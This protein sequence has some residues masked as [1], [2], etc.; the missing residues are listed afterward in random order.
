MQVLGPNIK[1]FAKNNVVGIFEQG[2]TGSLC[3]DFVQLRD[4]VISH[5]LWDPSQ[6]EQKLFQEFIQGYYGDAA[7]AITAYLDLLRDAF[8]GRGYHLSCYNKETAFLSLEQMNQ[9]TQLFNDAEKA[10]E[11]NPELLARVKRERIS[12][13]H[14]W[15]LRYSWLKLQAKVT[16]SPFLGPTDPMAACDDLLQRIRKYNNGKGQYAEGKPVDAYEPQLKNMVEAGMSDPATAKTPPECAGLD[17]AKWIVMQA[18]Q[19]SIHSGDIHVENDPAASNGK[20]VG[21]PGSIYDWFVRASVTGDVA[22]AFPKAQC[23]IS[24]RCDAISDDPNELVLSIGLYNETDRKNTFVHN[25][26]IKDFKPGEYKT[27]DLGTYPLKG[28]SYFWIVSSGKGD[29]IRKAYV[30]RMIFI[31]KD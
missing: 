19:L 6:D 11:K 14:L 17:P 26:H 23:L 8:T 24:A 25:I 4:W 18:G 22:S 21:I 29:K 20:A 9:A 15:L 10:V 31:Q 27:F 30:D 1:L 28:N 16:K 13:D 12:L 2:D 3:G 7:P 5:L